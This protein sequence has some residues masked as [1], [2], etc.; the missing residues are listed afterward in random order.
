MD[1]LMRDETDAG[2]AFITSGATQR[3]GSRP[4]TLPAGLGADAGVLLLAGLVYR[5]LGEHVPLA[6][7]L[8]AAALDDLTAVLPAAQ[9]E[10]AQHA[11]QQVLESVTAT[12][13]GYLGLPAWQGE[14]A[15]AETLACIE[16]AVAGKQDLR[17]T[18]WGAGREQAVVRR[19]TPYWV[20]RRKAVAYLVGYC[21]LREAERVFRVDRIVDC[22]RLPASASRLNPDGD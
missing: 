4:G 2:G 20:E 7:P 10:A 13:R 21:H 18:Y 19:V 22:Q 14:R 11:A 15:V 6:L 12:L 1:P 17:L 5:G 3:G 16:Q 8:A 9:C